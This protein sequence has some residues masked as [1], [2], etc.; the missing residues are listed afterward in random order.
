MKVVAP[1][2]TSA[3]GYVDSFGN[4][5]TTLRD[6]DPLIANLEP[7]QRVRIAINDVEMAATVAAGSFNVQEGDIA[8]SPG[9]SGHDRKYWEIFQ[10]G[11]SAWHTYKKPRTGSHITIGSS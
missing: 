9:S 1:P 10:R 6:G 5:K 2:P 4:L 11:G 7:G 8:F 3:I